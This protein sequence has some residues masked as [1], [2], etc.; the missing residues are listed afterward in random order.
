MKPFQFS[1]ESVLEYRREI[2]E[3]WELKLG[4]AV[5]RMNQIQQRLK[6]L[7]QDQQDS[8]LHH[9]LKDA[10]GAQTWGLYLM[11]LAQN[12]SKAVQELAQAQVEVD[13][14]RQGYLAASRDRKAL[15]KLKEKQQ[16]AYKVYLHREEAKAMDEHN[17]AKVHGEGF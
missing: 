9:E 14:V 8:M 15:D 6:E 7:D 4:A 12:R 1:L 5:G 11:S 10:A 17:A 2:E 3:E 16:K 13:K